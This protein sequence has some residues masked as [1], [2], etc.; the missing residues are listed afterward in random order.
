MVPDLFAK[1]Q[2]G[3]SIAVSLVFYPGQKLR[4][5]LQVRDQGLDGVQR[6]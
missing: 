6:L 5:F 2:T 1:P 3:K 4:F